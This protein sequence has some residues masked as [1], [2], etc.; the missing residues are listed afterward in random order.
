M[1]AGVHLREISALV[2]CQ[3]HSLAQIDREAFR[4][5]VRVDIER[6]AKRLA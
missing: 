3:W 4:V 5:R 6:N 1:H 2:D